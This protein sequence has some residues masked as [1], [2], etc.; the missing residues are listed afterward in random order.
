MTL[1]VPIADGW[2]LGT[3]V[4]GDK[5]T[6]KTTQ[7]CDEYSSVFTAYG[8]SRMPLPDIA[9]RPDGTAVVVDGAPSVF[10]LEEGLDCRSVLIEAL[11]TGGGARSV[12]EHLISAMNRSGKGIAADFRMKRCAI[13]TIAGPDG[14]FAIETAGKHWAWQELSRIRITDGFYAIETDFKRV[15]EESR[16]EISPVNERMACL[17]EA[18]PGRVGDKTSWMDYATGKAVS[19]RFRRFMGGA[20]HQSKLRQNVVE[21]L[22]ELSRIDGQID[23]ERRTGEVARALARLVSK[24]KKERSLYVFASFDAQA[25]G[26]QVRIFK[27]ESV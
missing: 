10:P 9:M 27:P 19:R 5:H 15:D 2:I 1:F 21:S 16:K 17:D 13:F 8:D 12:L 20:P 25:K 6:A 26:L 18:D 23:M 14:A 22:Q 4:N 11:V 3:A 7:W 24:K